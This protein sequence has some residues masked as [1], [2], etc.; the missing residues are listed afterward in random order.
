MWVIGQNVNYFLSICTYS[1]FPVKVLSVRCNVYEHIEKLY[2][3]LILTVF[4]FN[5]I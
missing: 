5:T 2:V 3:F 1:H 4:K